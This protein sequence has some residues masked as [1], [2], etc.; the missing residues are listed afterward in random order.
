MQSSLRFTLLIPFAAAALALPS[1][2]V[3]AQGLS[4]M[5]NFESQH[6]KPG[7]PKGDPVVWVN[8][9]ETVYFP[10]SSKYYGST[11]N[12]KWACQSDAIKSGAVLTKT[13]PQPSA[14]PSGVFPSGA[15]SSV[16]PVAPASAAPSPK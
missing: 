1:C 12:G 7:C 6:A 15:P 11:P 13:V 5:R 3:S 10:E 2:P 8:A 16:A 14:A 4:T 9:K